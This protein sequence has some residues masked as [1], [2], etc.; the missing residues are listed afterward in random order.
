LARAVHQKP[1]DPDPQIDWNIKDF[2]ATLPLMQARIP[3][4]WS[5]TAST[6]AH[7]QA[8]DAL[9]MGHKRLFYPYGLIEGEPTYPLTNYAPRALAEGLC[10]YTPAIYPRG[11]LANSQT[12][13][14]QLPGAYLFAH[15]AQG[16][17]LDTL[18]LESFA[19]QVI[20]TSAGVVA[21]AW[22]LVESGD[23][24]A[25]HATAKAVRDEI[26]KPHGAGIASGLLFGDADRFLAD[27][28]ANL[29]IRAGLVELHESVDAQRNVKGALRN[30]LAHLLPYQE[31]V[32]FVDAYFG[33]LRDGLNEQIT[34]LG[35]PALTEI[36]NDFA[37]WREPAV[38]NGVAKRL[39]DA[40]AIYAG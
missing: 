26:G 12:H 15:F 19:A 17:L 8:T 16:G 24:A 40:L 32:G 33:P 25:Q 3:E 13:C 20:P 35:E 4:P 39:F 9:E 31:R 5:V 18:D 23:S 28:A 2:L 1:G 10:K 36:V 14:M 38:R 27:L 6:P 37:N 34:R 22:E 11:V 30:L 7:L 21:R 29:E